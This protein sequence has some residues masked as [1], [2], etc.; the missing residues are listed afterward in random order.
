MKRREFLKIAGIAG[1]TLALREGGGWLF[2]NKKKSK[3][4]KN[5]VAINGSPNV[6]G[7]TAFALSLMTEEFQKS[8]INFKILN[9]GNLDLHGCI[10]CSRCRETKKCIFENNIETEIITKMKQADAII[11]A[12]PVF[13]GGIAGTMKSFLDRA[14]YSQS[15]EFAH[16]LGAAVVTTPRIGASMAFESLNQYFTIAQ[17]PVVSSRYWNNIRGENS[18]LQNDEEG[19]KTIRL[20]A[21]NMAEMLN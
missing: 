8:G 14:F 9:V 4:S 6:D 10:A 20:L 12:S 13:F 5:I 17:M 16:K 15:S 7:D 21:Q 19:I 11:L 2:N 1:A 18:E 3:Y